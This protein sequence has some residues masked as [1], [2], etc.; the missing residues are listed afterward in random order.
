M[1]R[2]VPPEDAL[3]ELV[4][5][6]PRRFTRRQVV[7]GW[8]FILPVVVGI[9]AFQLVPVLVSVYASFTNCAAFVLSNRRSVRRIFVGIC[10]W[11]RNFS[12][13]SK[14]SGPKRGLDSTTA[15]SSPSTIF[16]TALRVPSIDTICTSVPGV[17]PA[18]FNATSAPSA[19]SSFSA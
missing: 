10:C 4:L 11:A 14:A 15:N 16:C 18:L 12:I 8:V 6:A 5:G 9:L 1:T 7:E 17:L 2:D 13:V 3:E 19:I